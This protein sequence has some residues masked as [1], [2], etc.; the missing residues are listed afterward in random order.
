[1]KPRIESLSGMNGLDS[2]RLIDWRTSASRS[3]KASGD[4]AGFTRAGAGAWTV[5]AGYDL[6][7]E[8]EAALREMVPYATVFTHLELAEDPPFADTALERRP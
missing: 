6:A 1:M 5:L 2:I 4:Q 7:E 8:V 3:S